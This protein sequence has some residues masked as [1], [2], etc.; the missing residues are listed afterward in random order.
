MENKWRPGQND[1]NMTDAAALTANA[2]QGLNSARGANAILATWAGLPANVGMRV[3]TVAAYEYEPYA[4]NGLAASVETPNTRNTTNDV[5]RYLDVEAPNW[6]TIAGGVA[7]T[8]LRYAANSFTGGA[9]EAAI[10]LLRPSSM[11]VPAIAYNA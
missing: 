10:S 6:W 3:R 5:L 7:L 11:A 4:G 9:S 1:G 2:T 8:G